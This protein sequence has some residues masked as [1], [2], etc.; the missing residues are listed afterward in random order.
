M[1][2]IPASVL[3][4]INKETGREAQVLVR[5]DWPSPIGTK[6]YGETTKQLE[7]LD[8]RGWL[9]GVT[10]LTSTVGPDWSAA[11]TDVA[12]TI[13][14]AGGELYGALTFPSAPVETS[15]A[16]MYLHFAETTK[17]DLVLLAKGR[18]TSPIS[19]SEATRQLTFTLFADHRSES[20]TI[21]LDQTLDSLVPDES[22]GKV[23]PLVF[24][25]PR[26]V[27]AVL[28][29][30]GPVTFLT[31]D[32][33]SADTQF[34][35]ES[36]HTFP[37]GTIKVRVEDE[38]MNADVN[39]DTITVTS[40]NV[41]A[42]T[43][44]TAS[45]PSNSPDVSNPFVLWIDS[46]QNAAGQHIII[47][48]DDVPGTH[49]TNQARLCVAQKG[50]KL[51]FDRPWTRNTGDTWVIG[52]GIPV[53]AKRYAFD[54]LDTAGPANANQW[55][56]QAGARVS[57]AGQEF[58]T[59]LVSS[60]P[61]TELL[62]VRAYRTYQQGRLGI[63][64]R[65]LVDVPQ[66]LY[67]ATNQTYLLPNDEGTLVGVTCTQIRFPV[68]LEY[69]NQGWDDDTVYVTVKSSTG[70][71]V[72]DQIQ[73]LLEEK[74]NITVDAASFAAVRSKVSKYRADHA[75]LDATDA[76]E[77]VHDMAYQARCAIF[78]SNGV[79]KIRYL[80][81][82]PTPVYTLRNDRNLVDS[83]GLELTDVTELYT[84]TAVTWRRGYTGGDQ[85]KRFRTS[86]NIDRFGV[87]PDA[88]DYSIYQRKSLV[89][90]SSTFWALR[91]SRTWK[92]IH[93]VADMRLLPFEP[94]D[95]I[96]LRLNE[97]G[98]SVAVLIPDGTIAEVYS[99]RYSPKPHA[100]ELLLWLP[101]ESGG[102]FTSSNAYLSDAG[103]TSIADPSPKPAKNTIARIAPFA[104]SMY[105]EPMQQTVAAKILKVITSKTAEI[106]L[107]P[108]GLSSAPSGTGFLTV[109][110]TPPVALAVGQ[111]GLVWRTPMGSYQTDVF[112]Q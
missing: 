62:R 65:K 102:N 59:Y 34:D 79:A 110:K 68:A 88:R 16:R 53:T 57:Q 10:P 84:S 96:E 73:W 111:T 97:A 107:Y 109:I 112:A 41:A 22:D 100:V 28:I 87:L 82:A 20:A 93:V 17:A 46:D 39:G 55:T 5:V 50:R 54:W 63:T 15:T 52:A 40:R 38:Y 99:V 13:N 105:S 43:A 108:L 37:G 94:F 31:Q 30:K 80:S 103:D 8:I 32:I 72:V 18:V 91:K 11:T 56:I 78:I 71:N 89:T 85:D 76:L 92:M 61:A 44:V 64:G 33:D 12:I 86:K 35:C 69:L 66:D 1:K 25:V 2:T 45:R 60:V 81:Q 95:G 29:R 98:Q 26:D 42:F 51:L 74:T 23:V 4:A 36:D 101:I 7:D 58:K 104:F 27:P 19:Y 83:F 21:V 106:E 47:D 14:D 6:W 77:L 9:A 90:K 3:A 70:A 48:G 49:S 67:V 75:I 24:G